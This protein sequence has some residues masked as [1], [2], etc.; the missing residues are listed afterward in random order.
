MQVSRDGLTLRLS[1]HY[2]DGS[3]GAAVT[4]H[5]EGVREWHAELAAK[6]Y[7]YWRPGLQKTFYG[8]LQLRLLDPFG[9]RI[10]IDELQPETRDNDPAAAV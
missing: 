1:E 8:A 3:P 9:N 7:G 6:N 4:I 10:D 2:G 5:A